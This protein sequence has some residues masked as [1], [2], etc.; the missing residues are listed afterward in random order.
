[1]I[2]R[3]LSLGLVLIALAI[4]LAGCSSAATVLSGTSWPGV[5]ASD[6]AI[7]VAYGAQV[8]AVSPESG[9]RLWA[10]PSEPERGRTFYAPPAVAP[11]L[12]VVTDYVGSV[13]AIDPATGMQKWAFESSPAAR[14][15]GG[16]VIGDEYVYAGAVDGTLYAIN[17]DTGTK[18]W[19]F[20]APRSGNGQ[21]DIW[22]TPLL[23]GDTLYFTSL[24]GHLYALDAQNGALLWQFPAAD[25]P[26]IGAMAGTPAIHEGVLYFGSFNDR[27]YALDT[28]TRQVV[29]TY[30]TT[31]WVW[32][33]PV[34]DPEANL[35]IGGD[36]D[37]HVFALDLPSG[38][39]RWTFDAGG[40]VVGT[41]ALGE[42]TDGQSVAYVTSG[43]SYLYILNVEDGTQARA[44]TSIKAEFTTRF[45]FFPT[46][47]TE[48]PIPIFASPVL[49]NDSILIGAHQGS[50]PLYALDRETLLQRWAFDPAAGS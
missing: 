32:S 3:K 36:L 44:A 30:T 7:Y 37:G 11:E 14:F 21:H 2:T 45:L 31:N 17:R 27:V 24:D 22:S 23:D 42:L 29:W 13:F 19:Q 33:T 18:A 34:I 50:Y 6:E 12:V 16:A 10:F 8:Y 46:G 41:P 1:L 4:G 15:I 20:R 26:A 48:R 9:N 43:D 38:Q 47:T 35:M 5:T 39:P 25:E 49:Y 40:P 28:R